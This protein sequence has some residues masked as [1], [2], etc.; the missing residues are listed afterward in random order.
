[1]TNTTWP[2]K[3]HLKFLI[4]GL[5]STACSLKQGPLDELSTLETGDLLFL[6]L[7][8]G[9]ICDAIE[10]VTLEQFQVQGPRLS[11]VGIVERRPEGIFLW[12]AW[13]PK[14]VQL[15][16]LKDFVSRSSGHLNQPSGVYVGRLRPEA[17]S[18]G[19]TAVERIQK[20]R[21]KGYDNRFDWKTN[22]FYCSELVSFGFGGQGGSLLGQLD[23]LF[24]PR[25]MYFGASRS[26]SLKA[27]EKYYQDLKVDVPHQNLGVSPLGIYLEGKKKIF[28]TD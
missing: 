14:G 7:D 11:H 12:E 13:P 23:P 28:V 4:L 6:D 2:L 5:I 21:G 1:M 17:R 9:E 27:W 26:T 22:E 20:Q 10:T 3:K 18:L 16:P 19:Q 25:P 24:M 15:T 8:C